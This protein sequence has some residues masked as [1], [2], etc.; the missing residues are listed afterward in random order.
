MA[1]GLND[2]QKATIAQINLKK[3][4]RIKKKRKSIKAKNKIATAKAKP[5]VVSFS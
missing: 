5:Q 2:T 4:D 1:K 3:K